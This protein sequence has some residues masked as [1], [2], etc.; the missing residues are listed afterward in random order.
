MIILDGVT[1]FSYRPF[2]VSLLSH[3]I[4][5]FVLNCRSSTCAVRGSSF[6][7]L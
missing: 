6:F 7:L 3:Q 4:L 1:S 5:K 2:L